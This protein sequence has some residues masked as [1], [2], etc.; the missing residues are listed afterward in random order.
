MVHILEVC[1]TQIVPVLAEAGVSVEVVRVVEDTSGGTALRKM[2][3]RKDM[4]MMLETSLSL[5]AYPSTDSQST[6]SK[7]SNLK[8]CTAAP[9]ASAAGAVKRPVNGTVKA[10][11][12]AV[13]K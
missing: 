3:L 8:K 7:T 12:K 1:L 4:T 6:E 13:S 9:Q 10:S 2:T 11:L 5:K